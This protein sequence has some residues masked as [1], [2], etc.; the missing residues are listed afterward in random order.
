[1]SRRLRSVAASV[2]GVSSLTVTV[3]AAF[4]VLSAAAAFGVPMV[5]GLSVTAAT[6]VSFVMML[7]ATRLRSLLR[8]LYHSGTPRS[9]RS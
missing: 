9:L 2:A 4:P 7:T 3:T 5:C 8:V 1:M 6:P